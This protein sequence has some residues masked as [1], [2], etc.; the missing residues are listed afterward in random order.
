MELSGFLLRLTKAALDAVIKRTNASIR[1]HDEKNIPDQPIVYVINHF[2]RMETFFLPYVLHKITGKIVLSLAFHEF[3]GG[4]FGRVLSKLGAIST[5][6][7]KRDRIMIGSLLTGDMNCLIYPEGQM[8]KDKKIV[9]RGKFMIYNAGIRRP[10][11]TGA[12]L[13]ALRSQLYREKLRYFRQIGYTEGIRAYCDFFGIDAAALDRVLGRETCIVPVNLT[14][15]P[16]RAKKNVLNRVAHRLF[17]SITDRLEEELEVEGTMLIDGVDIDINFGEPIQIKPY[18]ESRSIRRLIRSRELFI[19]EAEM[20]KSLP[21][22]KEALRLMY[23]YM[24][25]IYGMTTVNHDHIFSYLLMRYHRRRIR[26]SDFKNRAFLAIDRIKDV[27]IRSHHTT[28]KLKQGFLLTDDE[29]NRYRSFIE[30]AVSEGLIVREGGYIRINREKFSRPYEFHTIRRDN[31][32][33]VLKNEIEPMRHLKK[34]FNRIMRKPSFLIR[35]EIRKFSMGLD[36]DYFEQD[37]TQYFDKEET[38]P[39]EIGRPR[40]LKRFFRNRNGVLLVHGYLAAPEEVR[41][42]GEYLYDRGYTVYIPRLRG[43]GTSPEDLSERVWEQ[44]Y[45]SVNRGYVALKN[46]VSRMAIVGFSTGAGLALYTGITKGDYLTC[47]VAIN[48]PLRL[49]NVGSQFAPTVVLWN[50][51]LNRMS[52]KK[53]KFEFVENK[54]ENPHINYFRNPIHG[55][56]ELEKLMKVLDMRLPELKIPTLLIQG[57]KDPVVNPES[58]IEIY[59]KLGPIKK[60]LCMV[61]AERHGIINGEGSETV[62]KRVCAY[63]DEQFGVRRG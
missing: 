2:T 51:L 7:P 39:R 49:K 5:H 12:A 56:N 52:I 9:E 17:H 10:P 33:E 29:H 54:P 11:H 57:A 28:L 30:A 31:I 55:I 41:A 21:F 19:P 6:E 20:Q 26:E 59:K 37:Y 44:W 63:L 4:T 36:N 32:V 40:M 27:E 46:T 16:I 43:H 18:M 24:A 13:L 61:Y 62:F 47:A 34:Y 3:F 8:V 14:Y 15:F 42:L 22:R 58:A 60:E 1:T 48:A 23:R 35:R 50:A 25:S 45:E 38:K 53:G